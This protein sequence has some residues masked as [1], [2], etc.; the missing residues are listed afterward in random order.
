M[1][2]FLPICRR[3]MEERGWHELDFVFI[4]GDAYVDHPSFGPAIICRLL[5]KHGYKVGIIPQPDWHSTKDFDRLG[6]PRLGFLVSAGNMDSLL[7]KFTAAKKV[8]HED[9]YSPGGQAGHRPERATIVL[10]SGAEPPSHGPR[11]KYPRSRPKSETGPGGGQMKTRSPTA[12]GRSSGAIRQSPSG[13][14]GVRLRRR[15]PS[16]AMPATAAII[17]LA[18]T[19]TATTCRCRPALFLPVATPCAGDPASRPMVD[20]IAASAPS[21]ASGGRSRPL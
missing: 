20:V 12:A 10:M 7:N 5:E 14:L 17:M 6:K 13:S 3:D 21:S 18:P 8:R 9:A 11:R 4:S 15:P 1:K 16:Q 2:G 19:R